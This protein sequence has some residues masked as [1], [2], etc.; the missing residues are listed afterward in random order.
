MKKLLYLGLAILL[1]FTFLLPACSGQQADADTLKIGMVC[2]YGDSGGLDQ[3]KGTELLVEIINSKGGIDIGGKTYKLELIS[4]DT[5]SDQNTSVAAVNRLINQDNV[6]FIIT[7]Q[8]S[9]Q[10]AWFPISEENKIIVCGGPQMPAFNPD[11]KYAFST[12]GVYSMVISPGA[13]LADNHPELSTIVVSLPDNQTGHS[14]EPLMTMIFGAFGIEATPIYYPT[15][16]TDLSS[17]G[18]KIKSMD[19]DI[20]T[21][22]GGNASQD[23]LCFKAVYDAGYDGILFGASTNPL[24]VLAK[25]IPLEALE[26]F[27]NAGWPVEFDPPPTDEAQEF[28]DAWIEKYGKWE[29]PEIV[30][31]NNFS[32]LMAA[33]QAAGTLDPDEVAAAF[34]SGLVFT[35]PTGT[36]QM[37]SRPEITDGRTVD[38]VVGLCM[39]QIVGGEAQLLDIIS[40]EDTV[41]YYQTIF[42]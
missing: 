34:S 23:A 16:S 39:K 1:M 12:A 38:S 31:T 2:Y 8:S 13:W 33:L 10:D 40:L 24:D 41:A 18:T 21:A 17:L 37:V 9:F 22:T 28:K 6:K 7:D 32:A 25:T 29:S 26:G 3:K 4:Y 20:F 14:F 27:I 5:N 15:S 19:P 11:Y 42:Q 30:G 35:G 36:G